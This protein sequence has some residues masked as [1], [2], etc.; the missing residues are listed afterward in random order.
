MSDFLTCIG[1]VLG[2]EDP[3]RKCAIVADYP[4]G[5]HAIS[6]INSHFYPA[7]YANI[8]ALPQNERLPAVEEAYQNDFWNTWLEQLN[9]NQVAMRV[10]D[11]EVN[12]GP[13]IG[14]IILQEAVMEAGGPKLTIDGG[15]GPNTVAAANGR[16]EAQLV[17]AFKAVRVQR[18]RDL[19]ENNSA[20]AGFLPE[21]LARAEK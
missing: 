5:S 11:A 14:V 1:F 6:G 2:N 21:W 9:S 16:D 18:Y 13:R 3:Q 20:E 17:T 10:L 7:Q 12:E 4:P 19:V 15:W 8:A